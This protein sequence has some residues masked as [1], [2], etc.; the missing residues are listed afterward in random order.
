MK[1]RE[2]KTPETQEITTT[3]SLSYDTAHPRLGLVFS[4]VRCTARHIAKTN[5]L[6]RDNKNSIEQCCAIHIV[7]CC[8]RYCS[9][10]LHL[11]V[12]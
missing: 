2:R 10:V 12:G 8:Q 7:Q 9:A 1:G 3:T 6:F 11:I 5:N 4:M